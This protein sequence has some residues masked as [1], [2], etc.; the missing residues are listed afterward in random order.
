MERAFLKGLGLEKDVIEQ[1]MAENGKDIELEKGKAKDLQTQLDAANKTIKERDTQ[2]ETLKNSPDNPE[3][4]RQQ[5]QKLQDDNKAAKEAHE[6]EIKELK[7]STALEKALSDAKAKNAKAVKALLDLGDDVEL[8]DD[9][10]IKGLDDKIKGLKKSDAYLFDDTKP[11]TTIKGANP[12]NTN[13]NN[14]TDPGSKKPQEKSY[15]DF[16]AE[17]EAESNAN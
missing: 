12:T 14:P 10:T 9:G 7:V 17:V 16:L 5:I 8:A 13:P 1:I 2:L 15:E 4:L 3:T 6:K 11:S